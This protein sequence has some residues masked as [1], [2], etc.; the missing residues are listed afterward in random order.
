MLFFSVFQVICA[1]AGLYF[2][3]INGNLFEIGKTLFPGQA[4]D[5]NKIVTH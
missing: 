5:L 4:Y 3:A 1:A 2:T